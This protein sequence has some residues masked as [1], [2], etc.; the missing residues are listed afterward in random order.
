MKK[1]VKPIVRPGY[2]PSLDKWESV[3]LFPAK[4]AKARETLGKYP[5]P[6]YLLR[7]SSK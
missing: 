3:D 5:I 6:E 4:T 7:N 2:N 1:S